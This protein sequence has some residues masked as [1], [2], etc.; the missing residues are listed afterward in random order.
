MVAEQIVTGRYLTELA[1]W[2]RGAGL[3]VTEW[4]GWQTRARGSGG[5]DGDRPWA[6][7]WHHTASTADIEDDAA[8]CAEGSPDAPI[9]NLLVDRDGAVWV[10]AAGASNTHGK[11]YAMTFSK[12][13][14]PNDQM[15]THAV[16]MEIC[17]DGA[18]EPYPVAQIDACMAVSLAIAAGVG[19]EP[20]DVAQ[21][22]DWAPDRK[23]DPA[24][25]DA[26]MGVW[27][28]HSINSSGSWSLVDLRAELANRAGQPTPQPPTPTP[29]P[30][31]GNDMQ[32]LTAAIDTNGTVWIG[33]GIERFEPASMEIVD[34]YIVLGVAGCYQFVN[35]SGQQIRQRNDLRTVGDDTI[36]ALGRT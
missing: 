20:T 7:G 25:A 26:V 18:G 28:P 10:I 31:E 5:Y 21:H 13:T 12:G 4:P 15:N 27:Q 1:S 16:G 32:R 33:N 29:T 11:G 34:N 35:T 36:E 22:H 30:P 9:C 14:V 6:I 2:L 3:T 19:L 23:I 24:T 17:N 8:Y